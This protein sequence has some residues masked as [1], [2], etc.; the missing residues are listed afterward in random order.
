MAKDKLTRTQ[1]IERLKRLGQQ[2]AA[3]L[4]GCTAWALRDW[5]DAPRNADGTYNGRELVAWARDRLPRPA[6]TDDDVERLLV[7]QER[8]YGGYPSEGETLSIIDT[9]QDLRARYGESAWLVFVDLLIAEWAELDEPRRAEV[10]RV[11][12]EAEIRHRVDQEIA[13]QRANA[14][15]GRLQVAAICD[16]CGKLRRG[17]RWVKGEP[18]AGYVSVEGCCPQCATREDKM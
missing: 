15:R 3:W 18:P 7:V 16:Y 11:P 13:N 5:P 12:T 6:M 17:Q 1:Q 2:A 4:I 9:L 14:A 8:L 10:F